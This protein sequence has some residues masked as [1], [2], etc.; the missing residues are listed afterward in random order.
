MSMFPEPINGQEQ[1]DRGEL[2]NI[3]SYKY[4]WYNRDYVNQQTIQLACI[5]CF[6]TDYPQYVKGVQNT[7]YRG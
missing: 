7:I 2:L 3:Y 5:V 1:T 4:K 6:G